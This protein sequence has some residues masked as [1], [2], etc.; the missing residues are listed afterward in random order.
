MKEWTLRN[1]KALV[2]GSTKGIGL[3]I[4]EE[5]LSLGA[6]VFIVSRSGKNVDSCLSE[7]RKSG[8]K[9][10]GIAADLSSKKERKN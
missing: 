1:K 6:E 7:W 5:F 9:A 8:Y 10:Y 4:A 3:A 2:T